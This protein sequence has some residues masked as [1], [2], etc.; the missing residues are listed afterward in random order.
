VIAETSET[1]LSGLVKI[2]EVHAPIKKV[3][4]A[5]KVSMPNMAKILSI[6]ENEG[7][8]TFSFAF[9]GSHEFTEREF[10]LYDSNH[11]YNLSGAQFFVGAVR[12]N[13][14]LLYC[15]ERC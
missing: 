5:I 12:C 14:D 13:S 1:F 3:G 4:S 8:L 10:F 6:T 7:Q 2:K 15:F 9:E 11:T